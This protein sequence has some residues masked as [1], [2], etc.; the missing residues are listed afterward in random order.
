[1][2]NFKRKFLCYKISSVKIIEYLI[3]VSQYHNLN[4]A[5]T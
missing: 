3:E 4:E 2:L 5:I 1:M